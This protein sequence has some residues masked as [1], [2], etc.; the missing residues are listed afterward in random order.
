MAAILVLTPGGAALATAGLD[1]LLSDQELYQLTVRELHERLARTERFTALPANVAGVICPEQSPPLFVVPSEGH[2]Q[3]PTDVAA[4][5]VQDQGSFRVVRAGTLLGA[6]SAEAVL[7]GTQELST[8]G[9]NPQAVRDVVV[10]SEGKVRHL[11]SPNYL[12]VTKAFWTGSG[13]GFVSPRGVLLHGTTNLSEV[14]L[15]AKDRIPAVIEGKNESAIL[16]RPLGLPARDKQGRL[17]ITTIDPEGTNQVEFPETQNQALALQTLARLRDGRWLSLGRR[18]TP[19][20]VN[21]PAGPPE[22]L[23]AAVLDAVKAGN[24]TGLSNALDA[25]T[26]YPPE[27]LQ[28]LVQLLQKAPEPFGTSPALVASARESLRSARNWKPPEGVSSNQQSQAVAA[29]A[30]YVK[31]LEKFL[32]EVDKI[33]AAGLGMPPAFIAALIQNGYQHFDGWW[34]GPPRLLHQEGLGSVLLDCAFYGQSNSTRQGIFRLDDQGHLTLLGDYGSALMATH[35]T[36]DSPEDHATP[37]PGLMLVTDGRERVSPLNKPCEY[38]GSDG[39]D[40]FVFFPFQ[41]LAR[42]AGGSFEWVDRSEPFKRME[43]LAGVD[44]QGRLYLVSAP[45]LMSHART[46]SGGS[47]FSLEAVAPWAYPAVLEGK[48]GDLWVYRR[49]DPAP[50]SPIR[51]LIPVVAPPVMDTQHRVWFLGVKPP[52]AKRWLSG[53]GAL[54]DTPEVERA[55]KIFEPGHTPVPAPGPRTQPLQA[56]PWESQHLTTDL[57]YYQDGK[58]STATTNVPYQMVLSAESPDS[59]LGYSWTQTAR[60]AFLLDNSGIAWGTN[61][62]ELAQKE[63]ARLLAAAPTQARPFSSFVPNYDFPPEQEHPAI[64]RTGDYLWIDDDRHVEVYRDGKALGL[65]ERLTL[66]NCPVNPTLQGPVTG[67]AGPTMLIVGKQGSWSTSAGH[68]AAVFWAVLTNN[69]IELVRGPEKDVDGSVQIPLINAAKHRLYLPRFVTPP[70]FWVVSSP[71]EVEEMP[72]HGVPIWVNQQGDL[73]T[74][75]SELGYTGWRLEADDSRRDFPITYARK[76]RIIHEAQDGKLICQCPE[77]VLWLQPR[78]QGDYVPVREI[79]LHSGVFVQSFVG[80]TDREL[81]LTVVDARQ[82]AYLATIEL[83]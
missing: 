54:G 36:P 45:A 38:A 82:N 51:L 12:Q 59:V 33:R 49:A 31:N 20:Q 5:Y 69:A 39:Q 13:W 63:P 9:P 56:P 57:C 67:P 26:V 68:S 32:A 34:I 78:T 30:D 70:S 75:G 8:P 52:Q 48:G 2:Q 72:E 1:K 77:G 28:G 27:Q 64:A 74:R 22:K 46:G 14:D 3:A 41:G 23:L 76:L 16:T 58:I 80:E 62:H 18:V 47:S 55:M 83:Q 10:V 81:F 50:A 37:P 53:P 71:T 40:I 73:I 11:Q 61:L 25:A 65:Q 17:V 35:P 7:I 19:M 4:E 21:Q 43:E 79:S 15:P 44:S 24:P 29:M 42:L 60:K 66:L 6:S